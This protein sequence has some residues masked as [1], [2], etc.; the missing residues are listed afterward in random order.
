MTILGFVATDPLPTDPRPRGPGAGPS[1]TGQAVAAWRATRVRPTTPDGDAGAQA[2]LCAG[3]VPLAEPRLRAH[4]RARTRFFD[5]QVLAALGRGTDQVV[6]LGAGYDDRALR[7]RSP[8]VRFF[9]VDHPDTQADKRRRLRGIGA[10]GD[11]DG[12]QLV[13]A[14]F[15]TDDVAGALDGAGHRADRPTLV[16]AEGL[17]IYL[18]PDGG[19]ALMRAVHA[20]A[21]PGSVL[22]ASLAVHPDG[23]DSARVADRA[24]AARTRGESE[25]WRTILP[26]ATHLDLVARS[27]WAVVGVVD[28]ADLD[29]GAVPGRSLLVE[30][31]P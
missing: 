20:R 15:R 1:M 24:N 25:P 2:A 21:A 8:G 12:P 23:L 5:D 17:L 26:R 22:A 27:G 28:D 7:F 6:V 14:D 10:D 19:V 4:L 18:E 30:G 13:P 31:R 16:L 3:M 29:A 9:E 11:R